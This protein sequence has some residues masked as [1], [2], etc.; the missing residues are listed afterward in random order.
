[1]SKP[2][3]SADFLHWAQ[4]WHQGEVL[5]HTAHGSLLS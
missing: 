4:R 3:P 1:M 5:T 2:M